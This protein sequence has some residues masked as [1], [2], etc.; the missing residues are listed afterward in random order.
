MNTEGECEAAIYNDNYELCSKHTILNVDLKEYLGLNKVTVSLLSVFLAVKSM[1]GRALMFEAY[2]EYGV[3]L[4]SLLS[5]R[6]EERYKD[7]N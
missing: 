6:M 7:R 2:A 5:V 4:I 3:F 1:Q